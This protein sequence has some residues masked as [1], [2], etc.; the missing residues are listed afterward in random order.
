MLKKILIA[1]TFISFL[2]VFSFA[3]E[4]PEMEKKSDDKVTCSKNC[5]TTKDCCKQTVKAD[6]ETNTVS[7]KPW[8]KVCPVKGNPVEK[9][10]PTVEYNGKVYGFCCPGCDAKFEKNPEKY[11]KNLNEDGTRFIGTK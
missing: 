1:V 2:S 7:D 9:D 3:Q 11:S 4:K 6:K 5:D 8:N 10:S